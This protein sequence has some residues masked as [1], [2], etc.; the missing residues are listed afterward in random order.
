MPFTL[1]FRAFHGQI[2]F[3]A[4]IALAQEPNKKPGQQCT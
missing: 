1:L 2:K 3:V 4:A